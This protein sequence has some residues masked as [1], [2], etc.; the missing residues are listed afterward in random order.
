MGN[1]TKKSALDYILLI[2][3]PIL[4]VVLWQY[5]SDVGWLNKAVLPSPRKVADTC[6]DMIQS[7]KL[8][9]NLWAS[10]RRVL[11]GYAYGVIFGIVIGFLTGLFA[12]VDYAVAAIFG[13]LRMIPTMGL[14]PLFIMLYGIG[15][16][17]KIIIIAIGT[18][19]SVLLNTQRG[20]Q[21]ADKKYLEV[22]RIL[23]KDRKTVLLRVIFPSAIPSIFTG[24]RLG[25]SGAWKSVV[26]AEMIAAVRGIGYMISYARE[27]IQPG[28][29]F[30]GLVTIG[31]VGLVIDNLILLIQ[32]KIIR[33][34]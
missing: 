19:W 26:A 21:N 11:I 28:M 24:L 18:F 29:M 30:V 5:A 2:G 34:E 23:E 22:A 17:S 16:A 1:K 33:W 20:I 31:L 14:V 3:T 25:L 8:W 12:K 10:F 32:K 27:T 9:E 15:E 4:F 13:V 6:V 7:G